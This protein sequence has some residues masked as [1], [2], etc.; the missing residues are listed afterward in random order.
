M[1][2]L[3]IEFSEIPVKEIGLDQIITE[4]IECR[5]DEIK[6]CLAA[7]A[8]L[9]MIFVAGSTLEGILLR[10]AGIVIQINLINLNPRPKDKEGKIKKFQD[11]TLNDFIDVA[12]DLG[13]LKEDVRKFSLCI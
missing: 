7:N 9:S 5:L 1:V 2:S 13:I 4:T 12:Y 3:R 11:W 6:K 8:P 10:I